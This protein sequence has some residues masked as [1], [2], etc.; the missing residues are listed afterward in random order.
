VPKPDLNEF[1]TRRAEVQSKFG[2]ILAAKD[3][4]RQEKNDLLEQMRDELRE[5][6]VDECRAMD[7][8]LF[9]MASLLDIELP[10]RSA[11]DLWQET[12]KVPVL[13]VKGRLALRRAIDEEKTRRRE[14][15]SWWWK[16]VIIPGLAAATGLI[17]AL[18]G[19]FAVLH[20]K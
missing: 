4:T 15:A 14:A 16:T 19:L 7:R 9:G 3:T 13:S 8:R 2:P 17:G 1:E 11:Q 18:T 12:H 10:P 6:E 5:I 20:H